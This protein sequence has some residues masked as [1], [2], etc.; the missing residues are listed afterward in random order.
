M[1]THIT[2]RDGTKDTY[3]DATLYTDKDVLTVAWRTVRTSRHNKPYNYT[4]HIHRYDYR[5]IKQIEF[6]F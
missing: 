2:L 3:S 4:Q 5:H 6:S 1:F